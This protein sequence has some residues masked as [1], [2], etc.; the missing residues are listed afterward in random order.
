MIQ[1]NIRRFLMKKQILI[2]I[3]VIVLF[4]ATFVA[5]ATGAINYKTMTAEEKAQV[6]VLGSVSANFSVAFANNE[7]LQRRAFDELMSVARE[8]G[9][10]SNI[11]IR[12]I[13]ISKSSG[14]ASG[15]GNALGTI[16]TLGQVAF[17]TARGD[18]VEYDTEKASRVTMEQNLEE[19]LN[20]AATQLLQNVTKNSRIAIVYIT[21][22]DNSLTEFIAGELEFVWV[23]GGYFIS[24]RSQLEHLRQEQ[25]LHLSGEVDDNTA[26]SIGKIAGADIIVTGRIDGEGNLRRLRLR[27]LK[28]ETAQVVGSA[29]ERI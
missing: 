12:N 16:Y 20:R 7:E 13:V 26:V 8:N 6:N 1:Y 3:A 5:C 23:N 27:A 11:D 10:D 21:A 9:Y 18:V 14:V 22:N 19:A 25:N 4:M 15:V 2:S 17:Y 24:D 28:T 29:S